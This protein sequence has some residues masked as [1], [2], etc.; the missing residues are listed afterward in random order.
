MACG[1]SK[2]G[3]WPLGQQSGSC[4]G[5]QCTFQVKMEDQINPNATYELVGFD[6]KEG[7]GPATGQRKSLSVLY[8]TSIPAGTT[9]LYIDPNPSNSGQ[10]LTIIAT[11]TTSCSTYIYDPPHSGGGYTN[12]SNLL[13]ATCSGGNPKDDLPCWWKWTCTAGNPGN[14]TAEFSAAFNGDRNNYTSCRSTRNYTIV[15]PVPT[16][17]N[18][19]TPAPTISLLPTLSRVPTT[20]PINNPVPTITL[21]PRPSLTLSPNSITLNLKLRFQGILKRPKNDNPIAV[22]IKIGN[23][24][25]SWQSDYQVVTFSVDDQGIWSGRVSFS[26]VPITTEM[27]VYVKGPKHLQKKFAIRH[28]P[29]RFLILGPIIAR[30]GI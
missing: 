26:N 18:T 20:T 25:L 14:Y 5:T 8:P 3:E 9:H 29:S 17:T 12:C 6:F 2:N 22:K 24:K 21:T 11:G 4:S 27:I 28:Q 19:P 30:T 23:N 13:V 16:P 7:C 15:T 10:S 1:W